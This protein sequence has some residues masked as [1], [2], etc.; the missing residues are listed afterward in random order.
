MCINISTDT[1]GSCCIFSPSAREG[2]SANIDGNIFVYF[3][4]TVPDGSVAFL[5]IKS[6]RIA[7]AVINFDKVETLVAKV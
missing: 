3:V 2:P 6:Q 4:Y 5:F 1:P 7:S